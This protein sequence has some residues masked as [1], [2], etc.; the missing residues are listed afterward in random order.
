M[1]YKGH[2]T[3]TGEG[4]GYGWGDSLCYGWGDGYGAWGSHCGYG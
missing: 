2:G 1:S 4:S 3:G